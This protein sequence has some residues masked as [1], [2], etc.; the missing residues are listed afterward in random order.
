MLDT[1]FLIVPAVPGKCG[2]NNIETLTL[3]G[4]SVAYGGAKRRV[5]TTSLSPQGGA[6]SRA[7]E[8]DNH[9]PRPSP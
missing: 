4:F 3:L 9:Y 6:Y 7:L 2:G 1:Y 8:N 5:V